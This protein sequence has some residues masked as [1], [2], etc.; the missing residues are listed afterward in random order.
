MKTR[1]LAMIIED[2]AETAEDLRE[3]LSSIDCDSV[4][5]DNK[6]DAL[7]EL[8]KRPFCLIL[9]DLEIKGASDAIKAHVEHG[10]S[11]LREIREKRTEHSGISFWLPI[12][13]ISGFAR[14]VNEAVELMKD[15]ASDVIQKPFDSQVV[16][17]R[18]RHALLVSGRQTHDHCKD[19]PVVSRANFKDG[20]VITIPGDR[21]KRRTTVRLGSQSVALTDSSLRVFL[22]LIVAQLK[23]EQVHKSVLGATGEQGFKGISILRNEMKQ[24]L[25][26][27]DI[28]KNH[29]HGNYSF[30]PHVKIG[31]CAVEKMM[32]IGDRTISD[33][34][35]QIRDWPSRPTKKSE[36]NSGDFPTQ[37]R[38]R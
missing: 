12:L 28:I 31:E 15:N 26:D 30:E 6:Q 3:I 7:A 37:R 32:Q 9:L 24:V 25:G 36:G 23:D 8:E 27:I 18:I 13:V 4:I 10:K 5:V 1:H 17:Q 14:E 19:Q 38:R 2:H 35:K 11:L 22:H 20:V 16:S 34:A 33:L 21:V 29:Y